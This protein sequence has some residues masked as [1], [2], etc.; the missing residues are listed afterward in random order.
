MNGIKFRL[1][2]TISDGSVGTAMSY[3][4]ND[5]G[6][7]PSKGKRCFPT[8]QLPD[9]LGAHP[10]SYAMGTRAPFPEDKAAEA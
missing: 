7:T 5:R 3:G 10:A 9:R 4:L 6:L 1:N 2:Y 8:P